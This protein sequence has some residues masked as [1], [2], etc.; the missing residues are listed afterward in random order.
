MIMKCM[1]VMPAL[2][3]GGRGALGFRLILIKQR[4]SPKSTR[5]N[6]PKARA[7]HCGQ[8]KG[9]RVHKCRRGSNNSGSHSAQQHLGRQ[10]PRVL[11][12]KAA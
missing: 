6:S 7:K 3:G 8:G 11:Y 12:E 5:Q 1:Y 2:G 10:R 4:S 9:N